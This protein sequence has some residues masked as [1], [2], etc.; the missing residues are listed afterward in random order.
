MSSTFAVSETGWLTS[1]LVVMLIKLFL[2][3]FGCAVRKKKLTHFFSL[4]GRGEC[5]EVPGS[6]CF[7]PAICQSGYKCQGLFITALRLVR[8]IRNFLVVP[9][10]VVARMSRLCSASAGARA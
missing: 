10:P 8:R 7:S 9:C 1:C 2:R 3:R 4:P 5:D 6:V